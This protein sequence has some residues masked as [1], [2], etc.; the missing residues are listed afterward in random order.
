MLV[1]SW[2]V[3]RVHCLATGHHSALL[4]CH[5]R[6]TAGP[7]FTWFC[8]DLTRIAITIT[9]TGR[10][11][12]FHGTILRLE[13]LE[14][15]E[16]TMSR[17]PETLLYWNWQWSDIYRLDH[18]QSQESGSLKKLKDFRLMSDHQ[19]FYSASNL[20]ECFRRFPN[21]ENVAFGHVL[22]CEGDWD[23]L[24]QQ[25]ASLNLKKLWFLGPRDLIHN[26]QEL[27]TGDNRLGIGAFD[28]RTLRHCHSKQKLT[29]ID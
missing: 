3:F 7:P 1:S 23:S 6:S 9:R 12:I 5:V 16:I 4:G 17:N 13:N 24:V 15:L 19:C 22:L 26:P 2:T 21:L 29:R 8:A 20:L 11:S 18:Y 28:G 27:I 25:L 14:Y 10:I